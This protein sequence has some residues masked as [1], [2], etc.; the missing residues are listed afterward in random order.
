MALHV[1]KPSLG[2]RGPSSPGGLRRGPPWACQ[3]QPEFLRAR[4]QALRHHKITKHA[5]VTSVILRRNGLE[6]Q[7]AWPARSHQLARENVR[8]AADHRGPLC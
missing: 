3:G 1:A 5:A 2:L 6:V 4:Q 7:K 8:V